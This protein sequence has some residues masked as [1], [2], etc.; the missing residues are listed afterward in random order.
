MNKARGRTSF[1]IAILIALAFIVSATAVAIA[2]TTAYATDL[3][4]V[5]VAPSNLALTKENPKDPSAG[6][7]FAFSM[8]N[9]M[10]DF[11]NAYSDSG[12]GT[13]YLH[14]HGFTAYDQI[15][16]RYQIDW[17]L[18]D[19][20]DPVSG[21]HYNP[22]W[23]SHVAGV[24]GTNEEYKECYSAW[25]V[26]EGGL[27]DNQIAQSTGLFPGLNVYQWD[28]EGYNATLVKTQ[29][30]SGQYTVLDYHE[31]GDVTIGINY[32]QHTMYVRARFV[33]ETY[34]EEN[35][36]TTYTFSDWSA[37]AAYGKDAETVKP[38]KKSD[39]VAPTITGLRLTDETF[40]DNP[41]IAFTLTVP[42]S[43]TEQKT[44]VAAMNGTFR[45][46]AEARIKGTNDWIDLGNIDSEIKTGELKAALG[47]LAEP[48]KTFPA[49]TEVELRARYFCAQ[50]G[51]E[52]FFSE[53]SAVI[54]FGSDEISAD[55]PTYTNGS[56]DA[57]E[58][59]GTTVT[60]EEK[61]KC[62]ICGFCPEPLGLCIFIWIAIAVA[63]IA[64]AVV[65]YVV[66]KKKNSDKEKNK[67]RKNL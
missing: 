17:A 19:V 52:D 34:R 35:N 56:G 12:D 32:T 21:W 43:I 40:N 6:L 14:S 48:G 44:R 7:G 13:T 53:Y 30:K 45:V 27:N 24:L 42:A 49:G 51:Q 55:V 22:D 39:V 1:V 57:T 16:I 62:K 33:I 60:E 37:I 36:E 64:V 10:N 63:V 54:G 41:V 66:I 25:D 67:E 61:H 58:P 29:L 15:D 50:P 46:E 26:V 20:N 47:A 38:L 59:S 23:E 4:F 9:E 2:P 28:T 5:L 31:D 8:S 11:L 3:P 18:D 65:V